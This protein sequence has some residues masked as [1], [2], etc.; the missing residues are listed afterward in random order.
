MPIKEKDGKWYWG[1]QGPFESKRRQKKL[2]E[3]PTLLDLQKQ[4]LVKS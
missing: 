4:K 2:Q 3:Q 1:S